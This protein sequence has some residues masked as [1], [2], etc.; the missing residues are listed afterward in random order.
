MLAQ[1]ISSQYLQNTVNLPWKD[2]LSHQVWFAEELSLFY[3]VCM[4]MENFVVHH[5]GEI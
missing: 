3:S 4:K 5:Q 1:C 2:L